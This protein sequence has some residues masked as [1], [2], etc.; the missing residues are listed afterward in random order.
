MA[1]LRDLLAAS[2]RTLIAV[3]VPGHRDNR[4]SPSW[5][6]PAGLR[7][8]HSYVLPNGRSYALLERD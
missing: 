2:P 6:A 4:A 3:Q 8:L 7:T 1:K 5:S